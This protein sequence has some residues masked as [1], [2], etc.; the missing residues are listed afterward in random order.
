MQKITENAPY[1]FANGL[2]CVRYYAKTL[3]NTHDTDGKRNVEI[4]D[5]FVD[6]TE[7]FVSRVH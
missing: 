4:K 3:S 6:D 1:G 2:P 7:S 5:H